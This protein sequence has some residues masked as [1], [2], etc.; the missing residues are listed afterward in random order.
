MG[1]YTVVLGDLHMQMVRQE[2][3]RM[4]RMG[5]G[6]ISRSAALRNLL[7][8]KEVERLKEGCPEPVELGCPDPKN[9]EK[10]QELRRSK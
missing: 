10:W 6:N 5:V 7:D 4:L 2:Q 1:R 3:A 9:D 8:G